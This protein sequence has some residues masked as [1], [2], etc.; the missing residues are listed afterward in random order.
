MIALLIACATPPTLDSPDLQDRWRAFNALDLDQLRASGP[1][2]LARIRA[3]PDPELHRA[4]LRVAGATH[5]PSVRE[6]LI[7][8]LDG[9]EATTAAESL[10][11]DVPAGC[12]ALASRCA[13]WVFPTELRFDPPPACLTFQY[14]L[15]GNA[16]R[17]VQSVYA[18]GSTQAYGASV[19]SAVDWADL[20][21]AASDR[22]TVADEA[23]FTH[24]RYARV[25]VHGMAH[26]A[27]IT[28][29]DGFE[30]AVF[31]EF[32][33][34]LVLPEGEVTLRGVSLPR[35]PFGPAAQLHRATV[36]AEAARAGAG[37]GAPSHPLAANP[38]KAR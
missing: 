8:Q 38:S 2:L 9:P 15:H 10:T 25:E 37:E 1:A 28:L 27:A 11:L 18:R 29:P 35:A 17:C 26:G 4:I 12:D 7:R 32:G 34:P 36:V 22:V 33:H 3:E 5:D 13:T 20:R 14:G 6:E 31:G 19:M 21:V 16:P 24:A 30:V 23:A